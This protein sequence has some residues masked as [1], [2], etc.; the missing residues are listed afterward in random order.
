MR[1]QTEERDI[2][3]EESVRLKAE[4]SAEKPDTVEDVSDVSDSLDSSA[5][6]LNLDSERESS[7]VHWEADA[8]EVHPPPSGDTSRGRGN[9]ISIPNGV[10]ERKGL[11][12]MDDSSSTCS[13]DS[14]R[15]GVANGSYKGNVVNS[16]SQNRLSK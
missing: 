3:K 4:S 5:D 1:T 2:E 6:I 10:V 8:A 13:N 11:S 16:R 9:S 7:P 12:T 15:S 14:I